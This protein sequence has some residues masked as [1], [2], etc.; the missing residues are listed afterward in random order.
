MKRTFRLEAGQDK[1]E[2][3]VEVWKLVK[4]LQFLGDLVKD[5]NTLH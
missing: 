2:I 1:D 3:V 4:L 5:S